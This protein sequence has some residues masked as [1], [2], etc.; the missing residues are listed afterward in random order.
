[1][2]LET[3]LFSSDNE[4][5]V[6]NDRDMSNIS[7]SQFASTFHSEFDAQSLE[8]TTGSVANCCLFISFGFY[9]KFFRLCKLNI[10]FCPH[11]SQSSRPSLAQLVQSH[12]VGPVWQLSPTSLAQSDQSGPVR[13]VQPSPT[14]L[15]QS[16]PVRP[17]WSSP[18]QSDQSG[19]VQ[20]SPTSLV[21]SSPVRPV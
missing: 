2:D 13:P 1:M 16:S 5:E 15:V 19:P 12:P 6:L 14:S 20:P 3:D 7:S 17:V 18:A 10:Y 21:Q 9:V 8:R 4:Q 11:A